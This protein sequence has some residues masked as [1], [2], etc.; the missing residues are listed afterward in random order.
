VAGRRSRSAA[1]G[2]RACSGRTPQHGRRIGE[3]VTSAADASAAVERYLATLALSTTAA[4]RE[5]ERQADADGLDI[6]PDCAATSHAHPRGGSR[7]RRLHPHR[8]G[9]H[10]RTDAT[11]EI[12]RAAHEPTRR[13]CR[14]PAAL[15]RSS[16]DVDSIIAA[17]GRVRL[18]KGA[19]DEP[20]SVAIDQARGRRQL[21][22]V[23]GAAA[24]RGRAARDCHA[25]PAADSRAIRHCRARRIDR[26]R[27]ESRC[28]TAFAAIYRALIDRGYAV[29]YLH[30]V[31]SEW[32][33][34][35]MRRLAE[36]PE[37]CL[38]DPPSSRKRPED[39]GALT[40]GPSLHRL[41][42][43]RP[44]LRRIGRGS[45]R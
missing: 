34:Y 25:R 22:P 13:R 32:Y 28:S 45:P 26:D 38:H 7:R 14:H 4:G 30:P 35:F 21:R 18:C 17:G 3:S 37:R 10:A 44:Q 12:W 41:A 23:D 16:K 29:P 42:Q 40:R 33:P 19:Y 1:C 6:G 2:L 43:D 27:F 36:R 5:C 31:R 39:A 24:P 20:L 8:H 11:L 15:R 9:D